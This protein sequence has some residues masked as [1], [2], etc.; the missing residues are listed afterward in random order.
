MMVTGIHESTGAI[1]DPH[2]SKQT[3]SQTKEIGLGR[4]AFMKLLLAQMRNQDPLEPMKNTDFLAQLAQFN[5]LEEMKNLNESFN[6]LM[7]SQRMLQASML[8]GKQ[9]SGMGADGDPVSGVVSSVRSAEGKITLYIGKQGIPL[10]NVDTVE[11]A[12]SDGG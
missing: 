4:D 8:I 3:P 10:E 6:T 7:E 1:S 5:A 2:K 9:V 12:Q 11:E